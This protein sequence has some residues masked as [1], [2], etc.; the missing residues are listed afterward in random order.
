LTDVN[1]WLAEGVDDGRVRTRSERFIVP[2]VL[3]FLGIALGW[4]STA[5]A[6]SA[7]YCAPD[8]TPEFRL[9]FATLHSHL[10]H[11]MGVPMECQHT[12]SDSSDIVQQSSTG[13]AYFR[14]RTNAPSFTDGWNHW[15]L[16]ADGLMHWQ[17]ETADPPR[18]AEFG[19]FWVATHQV[20]DLWSGSGPDARSFGTTLAWRYFRVVEPQFGD[21]LH[22]YNPRTEDY[23]YIDATAVG[24]VP[25][26]SAAAL[27][28]T[29]R[30][31]L[32]EPLDLPARIVNGANVRSW[33]RL[34]QATLQR[35]LSHNASIWVSA[36]VRGD[37]G[38]TW[39][40][41]GDDQY[42]H[43]SL[44]RLPSPPPRMHPGRWIDADLALPAMVTAYEDGK[45]VHAALAIPGV[46][47]FRTPTGTF[48]IVRRVANETMDSA[49]VG[50]P[51]NSP[52][53]YYLKD[54]LFTQYFTWGG[55]SL[56]YNYWKGTFGYPGS[57]GCL[58]LNYADADWFWRWASLG[59]VVDVH[60]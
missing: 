13:L 42:V 3:A 48:E 9:G 41:I 60:G 26:P 35:T 34:S 30:P 27:A 24:P 55:A 32:L 29:I 11:T 57:H 52:D 40:R 6:Q 1:L 58:G 50:I 15:A 14:T 4:P 31:P 46:V 33:P 16:T 19:P 59:T 49:T 45:A 51:R 36:S 12:A 44:V 7:P 23:A 47:T 22:V 17:G 28:A 37:D 8:V 39:Y 43:G 5:A 2:L 18:G 20:T 53:G 25:A 54:V 21:R 38:A 56:H 10:G